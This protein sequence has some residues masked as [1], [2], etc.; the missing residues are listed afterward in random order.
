MASSGTLY[1]ST[2]NSNV[3]FYLT[4]RAVQN[5]AQNYTDL[6]IKL[7]YY[8][9]SGTFSGTWSG[10]VKVNTTTKTGTKLI[11]LSGGSTTHS[12]VYEQLFRIQHDDQG[13]ARPR[14][15]VT[16]GSIS[17]TNVT[18]SKLTGDFAYISL[19]TIPRPTKPTLPNPY[20]N[21]YRIGSGSPLTVN[22][23]PNVQG[24][25]HDVTLSLG[26]D[27][28]TIS[29]SGTS[30]SFNPPSNWIYQFPDN[31]STKTGTVRVTTYYNSTNLGT[32]SLSITFLCT[33]S[34]QL[35]NLSI[36]EATEGIAEKFGFFI[37]NKSALNISFTG[38]GN[39]GSYLLSGSLAQIVDGIN[40]TI[41]E[42]TNK[43]FI[44]DIIAVSPSVELILNLEDSR[45]ITDFV[46]E[47]INILS[48]NPPT[49]SSFKAERVNNSGTPSSDGEFIAVSF[50]GLIDSLR[51]KNDKNYRINYKKIPIQYGIN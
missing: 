14:I 31:S 18:W 8:S 47:T 23:N 34:L 20:F 3:N 44:S 29:T 30:V 25:R 4:W 45:H 38:S 17:G 22:L 51:N 7:Y 21:S 35:D 26:T 10:G 2:S 9:N 46:R 11:T 1:G 24:L 6:T 40:D 5:I 28:E 12:V 19:D 39:Y 42:Y 13:Y 50:S 16:G 33:Y 41:Y 36:T 15:E 49:I 37:Q 32:E 43:S 48:Y 27:S